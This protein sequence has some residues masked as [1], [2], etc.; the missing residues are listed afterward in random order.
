MG[1]FL[2]ELGVKLADRNNDLPIA[3]RVKNTLQSNLQRYEEYFFTAGGSLN[4]KK[5]FYYLVGFTWTGTNW[6]YQTNQ[7]LDVPPVSITPTTLENDGTHNRSSGAN[8]TTHKGP[9]VHSLHLT[10]RRIGS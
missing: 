4:V 8:P 5:C 1:L 9:W 2:N 6:R 7:E 3:K 10:D